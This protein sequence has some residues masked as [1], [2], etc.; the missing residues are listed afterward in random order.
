MNRNNKMFDLKKGF[1]RSWKWGCV[2]NNNI[3]SVYVVI[4]SL[5]SKV[6]LGSLRCS[7][8]P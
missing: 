7:D 2:I 4:N 3:I 5:G 8:M 6:Y 1:G